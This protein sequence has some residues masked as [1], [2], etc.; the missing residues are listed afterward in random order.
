MVHFRDPLHDSQAGTSKL[1][2]VRFGRCK[3]GCY[4][5]LGCGELDLSGLV[6]RGL[7]AQVQAFRA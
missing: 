5:R 3:A 1:R 4:S 7:R 2:N 6:A